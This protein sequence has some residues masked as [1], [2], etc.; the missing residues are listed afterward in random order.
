MGPNYFWHDSPPLAMFAVGH[1]YVIVVL[2]L[3]VMII[4]ELIRR[5]GDYHFFK[6]NMPAYAEQARNYPM[7]ISG[8]RKQRVAIFCH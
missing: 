4:A 7:S 3:V 2:S 1:T 6:D 5:Q 8:G